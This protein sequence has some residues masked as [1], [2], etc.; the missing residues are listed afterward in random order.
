MA[1]CSSPR[2]DSV[3][4]AT[5]NRLAERMNRDAAESGLLKKLDQNPQ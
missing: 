2:Y 4:V 5:S 1:K 3:C